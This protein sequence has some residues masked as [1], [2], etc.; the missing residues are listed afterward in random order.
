VETVAPLT[1][2]KT[3]FVP[4]IQPRDAK[5]LPDL[6]KL[7]ELV[8]H[9]DTPH[10]LTTIRAPFTGEILGTAPICTTEDVQIA[11]QRARIAQSA[12]AQ[13]SMTQRK[14]IFL[15]Y[16]DLILQRQEEFLDLLQIEAGKSR[17]NAIDEVFDVAINSR[18]YAVRAA[19][20]LRSRR[21]KGALPVLTSTFE[22]RHPVGVVGIIS[23]WNYP[24]V[25]AV[26][27]AIP[28]LLAGNTVVLK[29][30]EETPF[31]A[32][33]AVKLLYEAGL[34]RDAMQ[35]VTGKGRIIGP[36]IIKETNFLCFTGGTSTGRIL[37]A[38]AGEHLI[39][40]S[41]EL[42]G[43]N[44]AIVLNDA[45]LEKTVTG[46]LRGCFSSAG[47]LCVHTERIYVQTGIYDRFVP[48]LVRRVKAMNISAVLDFS[49]EMGSLI[50]Q[51]QLDKATGHV[52]D[53]VRKGATLLTGGKAR[54]DLGPFFFEPTLLTDVTQ[55]M[56]LYADETFGPVASIYRFDQVDEA[57]RAANDS[58]YGLNSS[59]WTSEIRRGKQIACQL[60]TGTANINEA[61]SAAWGSV[62]SPMGGMK[63]SGLGRR[64]GAD[65]ILKYT[66]PQTVATQSL[67]LI[68]PNRLLPPAVYPKVMTAVLK[69]MRWIPG[70]R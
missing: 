31:V 67:M 53:A 48:E 17:L 49:S 45:D 1:Q 50:S 3:K 10:E 22:V 65:G 69:L 13:T 4:A 70:L 44:P 12:W 39:K 56:E 40:C 37:A 55:E 29:P 46:V 42:G 60:Q 66:E 68:G 14:A 36:E 61:F 35:V 38:Q 20:Y 5:K 2:E 16:H 24:L 52:D 30:S 26:S 7:T 8:T 51:A 19:R 32:L 9:T 43:K 18:H 23:P 63:A 58:S 25:M 6:T 11:M 59:I 27:D 34:P 21:R 47:Q 64:H 57:I 33:L 62:D 41:L 54:P 28:A 15:R